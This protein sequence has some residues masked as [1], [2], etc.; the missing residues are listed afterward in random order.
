MKLIYEV[1]PWPNDWGGDEREQLI[2][3]KGMVAGAKA[4]L[5][6]DKTSLPTVLHPHLLT[7]DE[8]AALSPASQQAIACLQSALAA[9]A[10]YIAVLSH[11][12]MTPPNMMV[13]NG[14]ARAAWLEVRLE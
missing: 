11:N 1:V 5:K 3:G 14:K 7:R 8:W 2:F 12:D 13:D 6:E 4:Q 10:D 9:A